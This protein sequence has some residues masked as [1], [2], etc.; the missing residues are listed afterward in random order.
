MV[1]IRLAIDAIL[2]QFRKFIISILL[3]VVSLLLI[4]FTVMS[5]Q[6]QNFPYSSCD[7]VLAQGISGT[8]IL[9]VG[10]VDSRLEARAA[11]IEALSEKPE[12]ECIGDSLSG[13][14]MALPELY[15]IQ[16]GHASAYEYQAYEALEI[17]FTNVRAMSLCELKLSEGIPP[18]ELVYTDEENPA[19]LYLGSAY[20]EIPVGTVYK[21][22]FKTYIVA[23][24][25]EDSQRW[26]DGSVIDGFDAN[27]LEYTID[28]TYS[29][30]AAEKGIPFCDGLWISAADGY[31][32]DQAIGAAYS[33]AG[34]YNVSLSSTT[35]SDLYNVTASD[36][37]LMLSYLVRLMGVVIT[38]ALLM[39]I[40]LQI[41]TLLGSMREYGILYS[42]GYSRKD[43][44]LNILWQNCIL[45]ALSLAIVVPA[46]ILIAKWWFNTEELHYMLQHILLYK[47]FPVALGV[48]GIV[49]LVTSSISILLLHRLS[50]IQ[51][52]RGCN[53]SN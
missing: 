50:P 19:Y 47:V 18:D 24:R 36:T 44:T 34:K 6:G 26:I 30:I 23:G 28:C 25:L 21:T 37:R 14:T 43:I 11:F 46:F 17:I 20:A 45:A 7:S 1:T 51:L 32:I 48:L 4:L 13:G 3:V 42:V 16:K 15:A 35:L 12:V 2:M 5:Y 40:C 29:V 10:N 27:T 49:I 39:L 9:R 33:V 38:S 31:T 22:D 8:G 53:D 41:T 52:M